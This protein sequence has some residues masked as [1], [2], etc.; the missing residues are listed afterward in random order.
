M[1][2]AFCQADIQCR[3]GLRRPLRLRLPLRPKRGIRLLFGGTAKNRATAKARLASCRKPNWIMPNSNALRMKKPR[4]VQRGLRSGLAHQTNAG[5]A[6]RSSGSTSITVA[7]GLRCL[8]DFARPE[9]RDDAQ[10]LLFLNQATQIMRDDL[11]QNLIHHR[12]VVAAPRTVARLEKFGQNGQT[13]ID[14]FRIHV[15]IIRR[16]ANVPHVEPKTSV[17]RRAST[18]LVVRTLGRVLIE[19]EKRGMF[20]PWRRMMSR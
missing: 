20:L 10:F 2:H 7:G 5:S 4:P 11:A 14:K 1:P 8:L 18:A 6:N 15:Y 12:L 9:H 19:D 16:N 17:R 13:D 3:L